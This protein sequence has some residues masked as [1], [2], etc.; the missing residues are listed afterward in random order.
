MV[1][2]QVYF[3]FRLNR[4]PLAFDTVP[5]LP[6]TFMFM[7]NKSLHPYPYTHIISLHPLYPFHCSKLWYLPQ[8]STKAGVMN[9]TVWS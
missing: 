4:H 3:S 9:G 6:F 1:S 7:K 8:D 2:K 5:F